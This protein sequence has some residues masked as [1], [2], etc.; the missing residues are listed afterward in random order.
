MPRLSP[1]AATRSRLIDTIQALVQQESP[2]LTRPRSIAVGEPAD[3][4]SALGA[5]VSRSRRPRRVTISRAEFG[6]GARQVLLLGHFDT[7]WPMGQLQRMPVVRSGDE[8]HGPGILDMKAG[9]S[10]G[11]LATRAVLELS[12]PRDTRIVMLWTTDEETGSDTSRALL[13]TEAQRSEAVLVLEPA[14]PG[15][16]LKT[17]R[18]GCGDYEIVARGVAAHAGVDPG[19]GVGAIRELARQILAVE[20]LQDLSR[21]V[22]VNVGVIEGAHGPTLSRRKP[23]RG[24]T[25]RAP[26]AADAETST[27]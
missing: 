22:S 5:R 8:L 4:L 12:P 21:G 16:V 2:T 24:W 27:A 20:T 23:A 3:R 26:T 7:V 15:G 9:I 18:K 11:M 6:S 1:I 19:K 17:R 25:S 10:L 14:L 13:E